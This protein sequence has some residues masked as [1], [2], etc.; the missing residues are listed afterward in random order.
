[1]ERVMDL[2]DPSVSHIDNNSSNKYCKTK[3]PWDQNQ[4][5][6]RNIV[7]GKDHCDEWDPQ[8]W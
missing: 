1:M 5:R 3:V 7:E 8:S 2:R 6:R 4:E